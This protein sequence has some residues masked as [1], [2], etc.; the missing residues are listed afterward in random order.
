MGSWKPEEIGD[1]SGKIVLVTGANSGIGYETALEL[2]RRGAC[3]VITCRSSEKVEQSLQR[4]RA[5]CP[6]ADVAGLV[7]DLADLTSVKRAGET[8]LSRYS[9]L[10][11]L[12]NNAGVMGL[13]LQR[14]V[15]GHEMLF[16][17]SHLG[18]FTLSATLLPALKAAQAARVVT[19]SSLAAR[20]GRLPIEDL[21][22][23]SEPYSKVAAYGRA[24]L[25]NLSFALELQRRFSAHG[26][27]AISVAAHPGYAS[28]NV[29]FAGDAPVGMRRRL[30]M[31]IAALGNRILAQPAAQGAWPSLF[32]ATSPRLRGGEYIGPAGPFEFRGPP[33]LV[34]PVAAAQD[35]VLAAAL[36]QRSEELCEVNF[37]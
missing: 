1:L 26:L 18:H 7:M 4:M 8:F 21:N 25:A 2:A 11:C 32:A 22:W 33:K 28:T 12:V 24:K 9:Q 34:V 30:W 36:W 20:K 16:G 27:S 29:A 31:F 37:L 3:T 14:T 19:V 6:H 15:Q 10:D 35:Q 23:Q 13:P 17:V 5:S